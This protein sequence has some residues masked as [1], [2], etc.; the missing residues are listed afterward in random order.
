M[1]FRRWSITRLIRRVAIVTM[2]NVINP[3]P[4]PIIR[5]NLRSEAE[6][7]EEGEDAT[8]PTAPS[9][10]C[11]DPGLDGGGVTEAAAPNRRTVAVVPSPN[12]NGNP[13]SPPAEAGVDVGV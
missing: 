6:E 1:F 2:T 8:S 11:G 3:T 9:R 12:P 4:L 5:I 7:E 10:G 13:S